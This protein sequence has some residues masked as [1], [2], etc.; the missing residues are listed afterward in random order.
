MSQP[1]AL[2]RNLGRNVGAL[3]DARG[4]S[5]AQV[6][7][8]AEIPRATW[9]NLESGGAN[10]TLAV[11][12]RAAAALQVTVEELIGPPRGEARLIS[13]A[14]LPHRMR[15]L[16]EVREILPDRIPG[17]QIERLT[18]PS[19]AAM[20]GIPHTAGT[21]EYL[22]CEHGQIDLAVAGRR[23]RLTPGDVV[24]FRGDQHHG[25]AHRGGD[26]A[27]AYSVVVLAPVP[28]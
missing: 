24:V 23:W 22:A 19:G 8:L 27:V 14:D 12:V 6:A 17:L 13:A 21:R 18:L 16:V 15:G 11:L 1:D 9:A 26:P 5:Q 7:R 4:L 28:D 10:P 2:A 25:Y 20:S 3:R